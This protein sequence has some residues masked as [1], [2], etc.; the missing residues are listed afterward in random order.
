MTDTAAC[1]ACL[2]F[3]PSTFLAEEGECRWGPPTPAPAKE[4]E[5]RGR[6]PIVGEDDWCGRYTP[7]E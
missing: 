7:E 5:A 2:Y 1:S 6:W 3:Q 4:A